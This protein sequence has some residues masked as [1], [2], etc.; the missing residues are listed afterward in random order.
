MAKH[1][2]GNRFEVATWYLEHFPW[3]RIMTFRYVVIWVIMAKIFDIKLVTWF[4][5][6]TNKE[7]S[8]MLR[9]PNNVYTIFWILWQNKHIFFL[10]KEGLGL[11]SR[12]VD[13]SMSW[14]ITSTTCW[15]FEAMFD[16][17]K[18]E[19]PAKKL[20][21]ALSCSSLQLHP[22]FT[23]SNECRPDNH[24]LLIFSGAA[25]NHVFQLGLGFNPEC[26]QCWSHGIPFWLTWWQRLTR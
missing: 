7:S 4:E 9:L 22:H 8:V 6:R 14:N 13:P 15:S 10:L 18:F 20:T 1:A 23:G 19:N 2:D 16:A 3:C 11:F 21:Q 12:T 17:S 25:T 5:R 26:G 24:I